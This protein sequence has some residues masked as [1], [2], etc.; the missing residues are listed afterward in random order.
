MR[1]V[2]Y[3]ED[4]FPIT[5][6][7]VPE[8]WWNYLKQYGI[9]RLAISEP[10]TICETPDEDQW[11]MRHP[12]KYVDIRA[13]VLRKNNKTHMMLFTASEDEAL[14]LESVFLPGQ[15]REVSEIRRREFS[16]GFFSALISPW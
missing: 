3:T 1:A 9:V 4:M 2:L 14:L 16:K 11:T 8:R 5:V 12:I 7:D 15:L 10:M 6:I 13:E